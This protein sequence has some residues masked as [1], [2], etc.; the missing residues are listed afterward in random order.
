[1]TADRT[2]AMRCMAGAAALLL[3]Q[4]CGGQDEG[5]A[6]PAT[7]TSEGVARVQATAPEPLFGPDGQP[8]AGARRPP[9]LGLW[10]HRAGLYATQEQLAWELLTV[11]P[12]TVTVDVQRHASAE[13]AV[14]DTLRAFRWSTDGVRAGFYVVSSDASTAVTVADALSDGGIPLVFVVTDAAR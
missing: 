4:G 5:G 3:A 7:P 10:M 2:R 12:Y 6:Q 1:M 14:A 9:R 8:A 11:A 13:A